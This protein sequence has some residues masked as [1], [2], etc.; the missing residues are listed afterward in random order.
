MMQ[1][2]HWLCLYYCCTYKFLLEVIRMDKSIFSAEEDVLYEFLVRER[3]DVVVGEDGVT[4]DKGRLNSTR[5]DP[6]RLGSF[7]TATYKVLQ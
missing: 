2:Q 3:G 6:L 4:L 7:P 1:C 5:I